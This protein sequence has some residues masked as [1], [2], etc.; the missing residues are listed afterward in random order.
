MNYHSALPHHV[1]GGAAF[2]PHCGGALGGLTES[3]IDLRNYPPTATAS[4]VIVAGGG[5]PLSLQPPAALNS[6]VDLRSAQSP[7]LHH[8]PGQQLQQIH[9]QR[10]YVLLEPATAQLPQQLYQTVAPPTCHVVVGGALSALGV[11]SGGSSQ[12][13]PS[14]WWGQTTSGMGPIPVAHQPHYFATPIAVPASFPPNSSAA[15][16]Q[17]LAQHAPSS[18]TSQSHPQQVLA[19]PA[20]VPQPSVLQSAPALPPQESLVNLF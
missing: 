7:S 19:A 1:K 6:R 11:P 9:Q 2:V 18:S 12:V 3:Y 17:N 14:A 16:S 13:I 15:T 8:P 4:P 5:P 10:H 20:V